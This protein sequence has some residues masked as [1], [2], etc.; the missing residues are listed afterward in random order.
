M[1][2]AQILWVYLTAKVAVMCSECES[3]VVSM[4]EIPELS[5]KPHTSI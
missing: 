3:S 1:N 5:L 4:T 2:P